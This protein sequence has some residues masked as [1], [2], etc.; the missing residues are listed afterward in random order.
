MYKYLLTAIIIAIFAGCSAPKPETAP[1]WY[2]TLPKD[3]KNFYAVAS[4]KN[5]LLAEKKAMIS[6]RENLQHE[7]DKE[8]NAKNHQLTKVNDYIFDK[9]L[10]MNEKISKTLI[11]KNIKIEE[12]ENFYGTQLIQISM[13]KISIY[14]QIQQVSK[15]LLN[16]TKQKYNKVQ[17]ESI[18]TDT[19][20]ALNKYI[21]INSLISSYANIATY[22]QLKKSSLSDYNPNSEFNFLNQLSKE[23]EKLQSE[24]TFYVVSDAN[25][26][27]YVNPIIQ[28]INLNGLHNKRQT[29]TKYAMKLLISSKSVNSQEYSFNKSK[30]LVKLNTFN[31]EK[32]QIAFRQHTF[33][34][35]SRKSYKDAK[36]QSREYLRT[37]IK[38]LGF[39]N[40]IGI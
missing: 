20:S 37:K 3:N 17:E 13:P 30:T 6:L 1:S 26:L 38:R 23:Y 32:E 18:I 11:I 15:K 29:N 8:F 5:I 33:V 25:S 7:L 27:I 34:G 2:T 28:A 9:V 39:F 36:M 14:N 21:A 35:K 12:S 31:K 16:S 4:A 24:I 19:T 10:K 22:T 40:F